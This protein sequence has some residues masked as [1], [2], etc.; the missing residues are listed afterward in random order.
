LFAEVFDAAHAGERFIDGHR[1]D[2]DRGGIDDGLTDCGD[3]AAGGKVH[4]GVGAVFHGVLEFLEFTSDI[5]GDGG[6]PDVGIDLALGGDP[7]AHRLQIGV[8]DVGRDDHAPARHF[9]ADQFRRDA[10]AFG[11]EVH[12]FRDNALSGIVQLRA[13]A[14]V[15]TFGY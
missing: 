8:M 6:V 9:G 5:G 7:D 11:D 2:G 1:A 10:L 15:L 13:D 14:V 4:N 3:I 12:L